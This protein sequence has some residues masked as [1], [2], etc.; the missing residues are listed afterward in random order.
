MNRPT[1]S[2][3]VVLTTGSSDG[4]TPADP[5]LIDAITPSM[6]AH[7]RDFRSV[8]TQANRENSAALSH[9]FNRA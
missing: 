9:V 1:I 5:A 8:K 6:T 7:Y 4:M 2:L 3:Q